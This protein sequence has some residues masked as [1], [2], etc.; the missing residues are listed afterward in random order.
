[1]DIRVCPTMSTC[2][3]R[4]NGFMLTTRSQ[5]GVITSLSEEDRSYKVGPYANKLAFSAGSDSAYDFAWL[6]EPA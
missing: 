5:I 3:F 1:M 2:L 6:S 4:E